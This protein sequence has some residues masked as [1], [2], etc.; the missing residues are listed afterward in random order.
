MINLQPIRNNNPFP[1][2]KPF[3]EDWAGEWGQ[4]RYGL[5]MGLVFKG[6][7]QLFRWIPAGRFLMGSPEDEPER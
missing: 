1:L 6:V 3:P 7:R 4:D 5:W 2:P